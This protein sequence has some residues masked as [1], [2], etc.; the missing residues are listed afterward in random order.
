MKNEVVKCLNQTFA[1][2]ISQDVFSLALR[3]L[4]VMKVRIVFNCLLLWSKRNGQNEQ[5][6]GFEQ[7]EDVVKGTRYGRLDMF[8]DFRSDNEIVLSQERGVEIRGN[9]QPGLLMKISISIIK[10]FHQARSI[11]FRVSHS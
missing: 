11:V 5:R 10:L 1:R 4:E 7:S 6:A 3:D 8:E 2:R 9:I